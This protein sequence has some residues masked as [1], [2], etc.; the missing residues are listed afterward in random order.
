M[1]VRPPGVAAA[2]DDCSVEA[3]ARLI[4]YS[5]IRCREEDDERKTLYE[6]LLGKRIT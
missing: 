6:L 2:W 1:N 3:Q 5:D 4:G